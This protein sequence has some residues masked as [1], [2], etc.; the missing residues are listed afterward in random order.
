[1]E[2]HLLLRHHIFFMIAQLTKEYI[3]FSKRKT[4]KRLVAYFFFE[5][6][7]ITTKGQWINPLVLLWLKF[8]KLFSVSPKQ[9]PV[10]IIGTGRSG[11]TLL[12]M[13]LSMHRDIIFLNEPK[14]IWYAANRMDDAI[15]SYNKSAGTY[16]LNESDATNNVIKTIHSVYGCLNKITGSKL[17]ADKYPELIFRMD[18][19]LKIFIDAKFIFI[20]RNFYDTI[21]STQL[22]NKNKTVIKNNTREDWW[23]LDNR[24][25]K[26]ICKELVPQ[27]FL[28]K[29][30]IQEI[31]LF[32]DDILKSAVEWIITMEKG[33]EEMGIRKN[34][35]QIK[36]EQ[37]ISDHKSSLQTLIS[38]LQLPSDEK[39]FD[40]AQSVIKS[41]R[42]NND[43]MFELPSF[44]SDGAILLMKKLQY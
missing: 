8:L 5:G 33:I 13:L 41:E 22:W 40:Y 18:Y 31:I 16:L 26:L 42:K 37:L 17:I 34:I 43:A 2:K 38:F 9:S 14:I 28:L 36:Y 32:K 21:Y 29:N 44:L 20:T 27:S 25:W 6:R 10:F 4:I 24:K 12:G 1:M 3:H 30:H 39:V 15:G 23:G 7:P 35:V 19:A 11:T